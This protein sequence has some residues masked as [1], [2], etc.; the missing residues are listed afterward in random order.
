MYDGWGQQKVTM[1]DAAA[2]Q[3]G[4]DSEKRDATYH[5][6]HVTERC[7][8]PVGEPMTPGQ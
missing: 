7:R 4:A 3:R 5:A 8:D 6:T 2:E 1:Y